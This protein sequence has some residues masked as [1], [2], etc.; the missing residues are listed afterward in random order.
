MANRGWRTIAFSFRS[1][2]KGALAMQRTGTRRSALSMGLALA[3]IAVG[4]LLVLRGR[5]EQGQGLH[6]PAVN[7]AQ[8]E[9]DEKAIQENRDAYVKAFNAGNAKEAAALWTTEGDLVDA[10]GR[11]VHTAAAIEKDLANLFAEHG[12]LTIA[13]KMET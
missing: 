11:R 5:A 13:I 8:R 12:A 3:V 7:D 6:S 4:G 1:E 2:R 10:E 9:G